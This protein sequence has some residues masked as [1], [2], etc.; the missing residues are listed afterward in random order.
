VTLP[1][2][3]VDYGRYGTGYATRRRGEPRI[4]ALI[5][6]ALGSARMVLNVGAGA[7]S[8]EPRGVRV[9]AVEPSEA[10]IAQR[11][12]NLGP[13]VRAVA[14]ALPFGDG[15]VDASMAVVTVHQWPDAA[16][17]L[18]EMRRVTTGP[19]VVLTFDPRTVA[20]LWLAEYVPELFVVEAGRY[21]SISTVASA[22]GP[23]T[24]VLPVP[25]PMDCVDGFTEAFYGRPEAFLDPAVRRSQSAWSFLTSGVEQRF[26]AHLSAD[27]ASGRWDERHGELRRRPEYSGAVRLVVGR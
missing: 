2:G 4:A 15:A 5:A 17:G 7:G 23:G 6:E 9:V 21:P 3:D 18:A 26:V 14:G 20:R 19:V 22:L 24:T 12:S 8:Y 11:P 1:A 10:M 16:A 13:A 25:V 27:L